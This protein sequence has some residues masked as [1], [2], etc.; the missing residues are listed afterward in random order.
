M[1]AAALEAAGAAPLSADEWRELERAASVAL[2]VGMAAASVRHVTVHMGTLGLA[3]QQVHG[4]GGR[5]HAHAQPY[6]RGA[7][8]ARLRPGFDGGCGRGHTGVAPAVPHSQPHDPQPTP[9]VAYGEVADPA[10]AGAA[11]VG[12]GRTRGWLRSAAFH[13]WRRAAL[14]RGVRMLWHCANQSASQSALP[15]LLPHVAD[16]DASGAQ[17]SK[18]PRSPSSSEASL[19]VSQPWGVMNA[20]APPFYP[21][22]M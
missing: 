19:S 1:D 20:N 17:S 16:H 6:S 15:L 9:N 8:S 12:L 14:R 22:R 5:A 13:Q 7:R 11:P 18:R 21:K 10:P 2:R 3:T 4:R